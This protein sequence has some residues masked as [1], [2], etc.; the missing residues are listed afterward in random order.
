ME[1]EDNVEETQ[2]QIDFPGTSNEYEIVEQS[3]RGRFSRVKST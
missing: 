1:V 2:E 3:P